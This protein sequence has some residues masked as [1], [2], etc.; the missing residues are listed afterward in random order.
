MEAFQELAWSC[1]T[2]NEQNCLYYNLSH[3]K[4][5]WEIGKMMGVTHYKV[6]E[7][8]NRAETLFKI[9]SDYFEK[10][11][12][13][14]RPSCPIS[15]RFR[16]YIYAL[17]M[18]RLPKEE[19]LYFVDDSTWFMVPIRDKQIEAGMVRLKYSEDEW[20]KDLYLLVVEFDR[21]N[22]FRILP[23]GLQK[24]SPYTR[25]SNRKVKNLYHYMHKIP[26]GKYQALKM[27]YQKSAK[28]KDV[29]FAVIFDPKALR[30]YEVMRVANTQENITSFSKMNLFLFNTI[31]DATAFGSLLRDYFAIYKKEDSQK[32][33]TRC[34]KDLDPISKR[35]INYSILLRNP[36]L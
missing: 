2:K 24:E 17:M 25:R 18:R 15:I 14:I 6:L 19:A 7:L 16:D 3:G 31:E 35:A 34:W 23:R 4:S 21:W 26:A 33:R 12:S 5:S 1:L 8:K 20:D 27:A 10:H 30:E 22:S 11:P 29:L 13:L 9:F 36:E 28:A 32:R